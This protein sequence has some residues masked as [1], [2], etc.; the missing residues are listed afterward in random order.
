MLKDVIEYEKKLLSDREQLL[1]L[2]EQHQGEN[3]ELVLDKLQFFQKELEHMNHQYEILR[4]K[5]E[6]SLVQSEVAQIPI[7]TESVSQALLQTETSPVQ[8]EA[9]PVQPVQAQPNPQAVKQPKKKFSNLETAVGSSLMGIFASALI[10]ISLILFATLILPFMGDVVKLIGFYLFSFAFIGFSLFKLKKDKENKFFLTLAGCGVGALYITLLLTNMYFKYI[11]DIGLFVLITFWVAFVCY[12]SKAENKVFHIIG[13][14][15]VTISIIFGSI[16]CSSTGDSVKFI[17]LTI[18]Y[19]VAFGALYLIHYKKEVAQNK[20]G[21]IFGIINLFILLFGSLTIVE[22]LYYLFLMIIVL[23]HL[24]AIFL[25]KWEKTTMSYGVFTSFYVILLQIFTI[26]FMHE[27]VFFQFILYLI[28]ITVFFLVDFKQKCFKQ[29]QIF[30]QIVMILLAWINII[31]HS[32]LH[33]HGFILLMVLPVVLT[34]FLRKN[35]VCRYMGLFLTFIY[36]FRDINKI[37]HFLMGF[38][39]LIVLFL[40]LWWK[41]SEYTTAFKNW[42]HLLSVLFLMTVFANF[43]KE[44]IA[45][46]DTVNALL[47]II[48]ALYNIAMSKSCFGK[49]LKTNETENTACYNIINLVFMFEGLIQISATTSLHILVICTTLVIFL[50]NSKNLLDKHKNVFTGIYVGLKF[51]IL[52]IVILNS[53]DAANYVISSLCILFA[54]TSIVLGFMKEY[55]SLRIYGLLLSMISVF[56]LV[57]VDIHYENTLGNALSFFISGVLC[58]AISLIYNYIDKKIAVEKEE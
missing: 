44:F 21:N 34:G 1:K 18:Y 5:M 28:S 47:F 15:G 22:N 3:D 42:L 58:F 10:F 46:K 30:T 27:F 43:L 8:P 36:L 57:M 11:G 52:L 6:T 50:L 37:E 13:Q 7:E 16:L 41:K 48:V 12:L 23:L 56:K 17:S 4:K 14:L 45:S 51:T 40:L 53:F 29:G 19:V 24:V 2:V 25:N 26:L 31:M 33:D 49:N 55:K 32:T 35:A 39:A 54:I 9:S 20:I 38:I